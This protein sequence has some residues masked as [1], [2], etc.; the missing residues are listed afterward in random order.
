M[1]QVHQ[2]LNFRAGN[3]FG[4]KFILFYTF[5]IIKS[6]SLK[7]FFIQFNDSSYV[8][9]FLVSYDTVGISSQTIKTSVLAGCTGGVKKPLDLNVQREE[10]DEGKTQV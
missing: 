1:G 4:Q 3:H 5:L 8:D 6:F 9:Q 10:L 2:V 7:I